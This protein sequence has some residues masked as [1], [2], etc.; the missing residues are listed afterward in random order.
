[1]AAARGDVDRL[2][3][4]GSKFGPLE[5]VAR[6]A[7]RLTTSRSSWAAP[8]LTGDAVL[9]QGSVFIAPDPGALTR[10]LEALGR[11]APARAVGA[12]ARATGRR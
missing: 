7:T 12:A 1:M 6:R 10:Y 11:A 2:L 9:G 3:R 5:V 8:A 4:D